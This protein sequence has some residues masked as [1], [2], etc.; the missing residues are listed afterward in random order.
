VQQL[1]ILTQLRTRADTAN[2]LEAENKALRE[3]INRWDHC[4]ASALY[5]LLRHICDTAPLVSNEGV[6]EWDEADGRTPER[7]DTATLNALIYIDPRDDEESARPP[8][9]EAFPLDL[10]RQRMTARARDLAD[11]TRTPEKINDRAVEA[12]RAIEEW[13]R[14]RVKR[15]HEEREKRDAA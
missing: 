3:Q 15:L 1:D 10:L 7:F 6:V 8:A 12:L 14:V 11:A 4:E 9:P 2:R 5:A 13:D